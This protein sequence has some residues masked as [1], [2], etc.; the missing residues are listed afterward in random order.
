MLATLVDAPFDRRGWLFE[1]KWDGYRA[2]AEV[3]SGGDVRLYSRNHTSFVSKFAPVARSLGRLGRDAVLDGEVVAV[4][5]T[6]RS[7]F[8]LLQNYQ[9][10]GRGDLLYVVFDLLSLDGTDLRDRPLVERKKHLRKLLPKLPHVR[11]GDHVE[12][13]GTAFFRAAVER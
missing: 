8:Q 4:D 3:G 6:G 11:Y 12:R 10:T 13:D 2:V 1:V 5:A 9:R 7:R